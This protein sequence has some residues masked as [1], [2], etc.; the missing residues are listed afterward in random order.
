[1][2]TARLAIAKLFDAIAP[3]DNHIPNRILLHG[4]CA[5][6]YLP[7]ADTRFIEFSLSKNGCGINSEPCFWSYRMPRNQLA[8]Y[9]IVPNKVSP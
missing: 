1:M 8:R 6:I 5:T 4:L 7:L 3:Y 2:A 9:K